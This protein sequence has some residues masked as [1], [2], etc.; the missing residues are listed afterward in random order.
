M[1]HYPASRGYQLKLNTFILT[2][3]VKLFGPPLIP[4]LRSFKIAPRRFQC[5]LERASPTGPIVT[6][7]SCVAVPIRGHKGRGGAHRGA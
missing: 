3:V 6:V 1:G 5:S 2:L 4:G 7:A